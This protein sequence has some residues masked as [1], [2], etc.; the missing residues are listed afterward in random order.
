MLP[1]SFLYGHY[2]LR[3]RWLAC[4]RI[5][6]V[7]MVASIIGTLQFVPFCYLAMYTCNLGIDGLPVALFFKQFVILASTMLYCRCKPEIREVMQPYDWE[8]FRS[9]V[10]YLRVSIP[11][12][13]M[14][15]AE[16]FAFQGMTLL[17]G[18]LGVLELASQSICFLW[19]EFIF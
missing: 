18:M 2:D 17:A 19:I 8:V 6:F 1:G 4:Q 14:I 13:M 7:P 11:A 9:W 15:C 12:T 3:K 5:T 10:E 16:D